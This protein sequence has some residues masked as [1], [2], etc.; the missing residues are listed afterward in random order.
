[1]EPTAWPH[2]RPP[3]LLLIDDQDPVRAALAAGLALR[4][5]AV[6][7]AANAGEAIEVY[8][9]HG[10]EIDLVLLDVRMPGVDG[11]QTLAALQ[12]IDPSIRC[13]FMSGDLGDY[14]EKDLLACG[15]KRVLQ[16][17]FHLA[18]LAQSLRQLIDERLHAD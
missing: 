14:K 1:M 18:E 11:P 6:H 3:T 2:P 9:Q 10:P 15:G 13:C 4:G 12:T 7:T 16:K 8:R 17:P 5:F